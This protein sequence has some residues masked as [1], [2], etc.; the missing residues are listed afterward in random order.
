MRVQRVVMRDSEEES[1]TLLAE[2]H[3][4]VESVERF[5]SY[6]VSIE[7]SPNTVKAYAHDLKDWF[8]YLAGHG[9]DW[10]RATLEDSI[11]VSC[12]GVSYGPAPA[13]CGRGRHCR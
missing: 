1:W 3:G 8:T 7:K 4:P 5:L 2:D 10:R 12:S 11:Q 6:L 9:L 13:A